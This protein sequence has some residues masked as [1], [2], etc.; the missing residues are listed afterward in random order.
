[1]ASLGENR[2]GKARVRVMK[3]VRHETHHAMKEWNVR[4]LLHG[5]FESCFNAGDNS[6]ILPT[7]TMKNTVYY[8]AR[9]SQAATLEEFAIELI[10]YLLAKNPQVSKASAEVEEKSWGQLSIDGA[11]HPTTYRMNGPELQTVE[12]LRERDGNLQLT[13]GIDGLMILKTTKSAFTGYI[14]DKLTTLPESTDRDS[15]LGVS[16]NAGRLRGCPAISNRRAAQGLRGARQPKRA[17]HSLRYRSGDA[18]CR[19]GDGARQAHHAQPALQSG[20][21]QPLRTG[22]S[23]P[24]FRAH[25]RAPWVHR[26]GR[27]AIA[28]TPSSKRVIVCQAACNPSKAHTSSTSTVNG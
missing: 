2:Y 15:C 24:D 25:R 22:E 6:K 13:S 11:P 27:H 4:V 19:S 20:G 23:Q 12:A 17:A 8:L 18:R 16:G 28:A 26:S 14:K 5:D 9:E 21:P 10:D 7:D 1:M 3:V